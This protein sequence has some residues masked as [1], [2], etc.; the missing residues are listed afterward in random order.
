M[1]N[2]AIKIPFGAAEAP[3]YNDST[4][5]KIFRTP[6]GQY[7][8]ATVLLTPKLHHQISSY[9]EHMDVVRRKQNF[10]HPLVNKLKKLAAAAAVSNDPSDPVTGGGNHTGTD[11][12][13]Q[14]S[15]GGKGKLSNPYFV[16][17]TFKYAGPPNGYDWGPQRLNYSSLKMILQRNG[18]KDFDVVYVGKWDATGY[19]TSKGRTSFIAVG[20]GGNLVWR[21]Y[22]SDSP[23]SGQNELFFKGKKVHT[24]SFLSASTIKQDKMIKQ[25]LT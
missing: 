10:L 7:A 16:G 12:P 2:H 8:M 25:L 20:V 15:T 4:T 9:I 14:I 17:A 11:V 5:W 1:K 19:S 23:M 22:A 13:L 24:S 3:P 6:Y 18:I 21:K